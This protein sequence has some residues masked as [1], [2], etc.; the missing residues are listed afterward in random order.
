MQHFKVAQLSSVTVD[1]DAEKNGSRLFWNTNI[2]HSSISGNYVFFW[3]KSCGSSKSLCY[4]VLVLIHQT[5]RLDQ[6]LAITMFLHLSPHLSVWFFSLSVHGDTKTE[7]EL[8]PYPT[9]IHLSGEIWPVADKISWKTVVLITIT[10][11]FFNCD[12]RNTIITKFFPETSSLSSD[13]QQ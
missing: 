13:V 8:L 11:Y 7:F 4:S 9:F 1:A 3:L 2:L 5:H 12:V 6:N 10:I